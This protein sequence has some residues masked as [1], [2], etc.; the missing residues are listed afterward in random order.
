MLAD[1]IAAREIE[2]AAF[3]FQE[4]FFE[5]RIASLLGTVPGFD[6]MPIAAADLAQRE[7]HGNTTTSAE[8]NHDR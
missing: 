7:E 5:C 3:N 1:S 8:F 2:P 4:R 6:R